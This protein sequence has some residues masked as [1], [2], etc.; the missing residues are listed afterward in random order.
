MMLTV[1]ADTIL[2]ALE[3]ANNNNHAE[4]SKALHHNCDRL[5]TELLL[6]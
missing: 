2:K 5:T 4:C 1:A 3:A 6:Q